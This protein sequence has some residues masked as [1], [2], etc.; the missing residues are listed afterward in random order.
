MKTQLNNLKLNYYQILLDQTLQPYIQ[1]LLEHN[2]IKTLDP[3]AKLATIDIILAREGARFHLSQIGYYILKEHL[4][5]KEQ[6]SFTK[7]EVIAFAEKESKKPLRNKFHPALE[8]PTSLVTRSKVY[9]CMHAAAQYEELYTVLTGEKE[10]AA[11]ILMYDL[12]NYDYNSIFLR[13]NFC[14]KGALNQRDFSQ[15]EKDFLSLQ[16]KE[17]MTEKKLR[18]I[19]EIVE[20]TKEQRRV[21]QKNKDSI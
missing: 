15:E 1:E 21:Y 12:K 11:I 16:E 5:T 4:E 13:Y 14:L 10:E 7:E 6:R 18:I 2:L 17:E 9:Q 8:E 19:K 3:I 20:L